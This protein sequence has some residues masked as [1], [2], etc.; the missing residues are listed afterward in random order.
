MKRKAV[1][2]ADFDEMKKRTV[3][4]IKERVGSAQAETIT[5][6]DL[7]RIVG[8]HQNSRQFQRLLDEIAEDALPK[9]KCLVTA[10]VVS[11]TDGSPGAGFFYMARKHYGYEAGV[12]KH[13]DER[14][15]LIQ[16]GQAIAYWRS[17]LESG[18][19]V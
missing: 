13:E 5:Y 15:H 18:S 2:P 14:F 8:V 16:Q 11:K 17:I 3:E 4:A 10:V 12:D 6:V 7:A 19:A 1:P 9:A